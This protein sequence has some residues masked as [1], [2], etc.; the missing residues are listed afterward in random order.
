MGAFVNHAVDA[1]MPWIPVGARPMLDM[2]FNARRLR[3]N[4]LRSD[5]AMS[6]LSAL[7]IDRALVERVGLGIKEPYV[8]ANGVEVSGVITYPLEVSGE[9][10]RYGYLALP[11]ITANPNHHLAWSPGA[12]RTVAFGEA[13]PLFVVSA[14]LA[15][16]QARSVIEAQHVSAC[17]I[18]SSQPDRLP[19]EWHAS[20]FWARWDRI[21]L[22][23]AL[24]PSMKAAIATSAGRPVETAA[25]VTLDCC[26]CDS[27]SAALREWLDRVLTE[28]RPLV[29]DVRAAGLVGACAGDYA[30][31]PISLHGGVAGGRMYYPFVIERRRPAGHGGPLMFSYETIVVRSDGAVLEA[32][33]LPAPAG[34]SS[35]QRVHCLTDGTR[36]AAPPAQS[37]N[38]TWSFEAIQRFIAGRAAGVD[39]A[40]R[41]AREVVSDVHAMLASR[42]ALPEPSDLW[43][44]ATFVVM[45]HMFRLFPAIPLLLVEGPRGSG[46]SELA[47]AV[48][49]LGF[50]AVTMGQGSA[51]TLVRITQEC[52]G[53]V[54]LDDVEGLSAGGAGFGELSQ[55]LKVGYRASTA[56]KPVTLSSGRVETFDFF[57][58][59]LLTCTQGV[60]P[61][62]GSRCISIR[63]APIGGG[64]P[65][66]TADPDALRDELHIL[67]MTS[68]TS[69]LDCYAALEGGEGRV[70]E[71]WAP[72]LAIA[73]AVAPADAAA[74]VRAAKV[75]H[76][77]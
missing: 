5:A 36:I 22:D 20:S 10:R 76:T 17:V 2:G 14:P 63:T 26:R 74:A 18:T 51:A 3:A 40:T 15:F 19:G 65:P 1:K 71:I 4:L 8:T 23:E 21:I 66:H 73:D 47:S 55:C 41:P 46:K 48:S 29:V 49:S 6:A 58:P 39:P 64:L 37:R 32:K 54:V 52:G 34:T 12:A 31:T 28:A 56:R 77:A 70:D 68:G 33:T 67:G 50:N 35:G 27:V 62:L 57:G 13:G 53:L 24:P 7:G 44:V 25:D 38:A 72:M 11:G 30:A 59:R 9:R 60:E 16:F 69:V 43:V 42:V 61:I 75:R 45:T